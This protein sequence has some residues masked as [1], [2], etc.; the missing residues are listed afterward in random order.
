MWKGIDVSSNQG[1]INWGAVKAAGC[2]FAIL[3]S[4]VKAGTPDKQFARNVAG[5]RAQ[6]IPFEGYKYMYALTP[7]QSVEEA[8]KVVALLRSHGLTC[9]VWWDV[10]D[11]S[12][13]TLNQGV[14]TGLIQSAADVII[15]AGFEFGIY[16]GKSFYQEGVFD[17]TAFDCPFWMA[18]YPLSGYYT[19]ADN[20]PADK[21]KPAPSQPLVAWQYTS[22]GRVDGITGPVDL[23]ICYIPFW[24]TQA[25]E[26]Y[27][28]DIWHG[29]SIIKALE[30]IGEDGSYQHRA[31]IA[32]A[33]G[34]AGYSGT[35]VQNTHMLN[36][37]RT[38]QLRKV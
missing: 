36:L 17:I 33:N 37:L 31:Q 13:R 20:P 4:T 2:D 27:L 9:R 5:C 16:T 35:T 38:G 22:K 32:A 30:S 14:L 1:T 8:M 3:R 15:G 6:G 19:L 34:I 24:E 10:E 26:Y 7:T 25:P 29:T 12:L 21:Y 28:Q 23:N 18:R 11:N